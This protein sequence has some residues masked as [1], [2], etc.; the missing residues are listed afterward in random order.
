MMKQCIPFLEDIVC[1][2]VTPPEGFFRSKISI[3]TDALPA[4]S[5]VSPEEEAAQ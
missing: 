2:G 4:P 3:S 1:G 5:N